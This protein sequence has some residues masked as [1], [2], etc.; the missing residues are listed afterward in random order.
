MMFDL[1]IK[2]GTVVDGTGNHWYHADI[3]I[4]NDVITAIGELGDSSSVR[5]ISA[6]DKIVA[7][8]FIDVHSH[9]DYLILSDPLASSKVLAGVTTDVSGNCGGSAAPQN[10]MFWQEWWTEDV[11][12]RFKLV[13]REYAAHT[14]KR[15]NIN[16]NW[17]TMGEYLAEVRKTGIS[18]NYANFVGHY[19]LR[20]AAYH[21]ERRKPS[22]EELDLM[23]KML[24][25]SMQEGAIGFS[26]EVGSHFIWEYEI[27][28]LL[29]LCE[30]T[31]DLGGVFSYDINNYADRFLEDLEKAL[32]VV[33]K[34]RV[35]T[36]ISHIQVYG[37]ENSGKAKYA[38]QMIEDTR[39]R[40]VNVVSDVMAAANGGGLFFSA[41]TRDMF[42]QWA[43]DEL[44]SVLKSCTGRGKL[45]EALERGEAS[46]FYVSPSRTEEEKKNG[47]VYSYGPLKDPLWQHYVKIVSSEDKSLEGKTIYQLMR[48]RN[49]DDKFKLLFDLVE[50]EPELRSILDI[51]HP[52][53]MRDVV[54][55]PNVAFGTDGGLV[56]AIRRPQIPNPCLYATFPMVLRKYVR[57]G[58]ELRLEDAIRKMTSLPATAIKQYDRGILRP[59]FKADCVIFDYD[60]VGEVAAYGDKIPEVFSKGIEWVV[61]NGQVVVENGLHQHTR[62]GQVLTHKSFYKNTH[63]N[64]HKNKGEE[65]V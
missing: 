64:T 36:I 32:W 55:D 35:P 16:F 26:T 18:L 58:K 4:Q 62:P 52:D 59:G 27:E 42:P 46:E 48:E 6:K 21:Q 43:I 61:V 20:I 60:T 15:H 57:E 63:K 41:R 45:K 50:K 3:G 54:T 2:D 29:E 25:Q 8:G 56:D 33:E 24:A 10:K 19:T 7:P 11:D 12:E 13:D 5:T 1:L 44:P 51:I 34:T 53:N 65:T 37:R 47:M 22:R 40:G 49:I 23:K 30:L 38:L 28:E 14:L 17:N 31:R 39:S 9:S